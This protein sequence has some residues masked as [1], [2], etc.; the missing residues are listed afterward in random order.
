MTSRTRKRRETVWWTVTAAVLAAG[1]L[2]WWFAVRRAETPGLPASQPGARAL[3][4]APGGPREESGHD[5]VTG[6]E[7]AAL[8]RVLRERGAAS[9]GR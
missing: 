3:S 8:E 4:E 7:K 2:A 6:E 5:E 9:P 1:L